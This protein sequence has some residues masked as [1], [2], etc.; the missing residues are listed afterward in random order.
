M[1]L[2]IISPISHQTQ[3]LLH[4]MM[5]IFFIAHHFEYK[6]IIIIN[7][8]LFSKQVF[9]GRKYS[10]QELIFSPAVKFLN[11]FVLIIKHLARPGLGSAL[12]R[13]N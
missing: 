2:A 7:T 5:S 10:V 3:T 9:L 1:R 4:N 6:L 13:L 12:A 11:N 8:K